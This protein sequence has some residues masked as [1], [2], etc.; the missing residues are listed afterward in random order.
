[1]QPKLI[2]SLLVTVISKLA[3]V[4]VLAVCRIATVGTPVWSLAQQLQPFGAVAVL[5]IVMTIVQAEPVPEVNLPAVAPPTRVLSEQP[6][7]EVKV[8]PAEITP[9]S[10]RRPLLFAE[11]VPICQTPAALRERLVSAAV[12]GKMVPTK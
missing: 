5:P 3:V 9:A 8:V 6:A 11:V 1:M 2:T 4:V 12:V 7:F 10:S